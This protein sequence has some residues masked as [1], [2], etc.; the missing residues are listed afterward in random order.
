MAK[1]KDIPNIS[2][3]LP[4]ASTAKM[5]FRPQTQKKEE[6][7]KERETKCRIPYSLGEFAADDDRLC[8]LIINNSPKG[9]DAG[10]PRS[11]IGIKTGQHPIT[12]TLHGPKAANG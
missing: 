5:I 12:K 9:E 4:K 7:K 8:L 11:S 1:V 2:Y 10:D 6:K 3:K